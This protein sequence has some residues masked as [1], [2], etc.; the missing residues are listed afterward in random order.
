MRYPDWEHDISANTV[1]DK[2]SEYDRLILAIQRESKNQNSKSYDN[3]QIGIMLLGAIIIPAFLVF[4]KMIVGYS[5]LTEYGLVKSVLIPEGL[6][7]AIYQ[8]IEWQKNK[9]EYREQGLRSQRM[10]EYKIEYSKYLELKNEAESYLKRVAEINALNDKQKPQFWV[11]LT[12]LEFEHEIARLLKAMGFDTEVTKAS[13]D[14]GI[15]VIAKYDG[16]IIAVQCKAHSKK[17]SERVA[18]DLYGV[19]HGYGFDEGFIM[20]L[21][22][23]TQPTLR[24]CNS[25]TDRPIQVFALDDLMKMAAG[26]ITADEIVLT[27][28]GT[29]KDSTNLS[30]YEYKKAADHIEY[31]IYRHNF[32]PEDK[33]RRR[34]KRY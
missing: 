22:G 11:N 6:C 14:H 9:V 16:R 27:S 3:V 21:R 26:Q 20:S 15:D 8:I 34:R 19:L 13:G 28:D 29:G 12:G 5:I 2:C 18:R 30:N 1:I 33:Y 25:I 32:F 10:E 24:F 4:S 31:A 23:A 7:F 17:L